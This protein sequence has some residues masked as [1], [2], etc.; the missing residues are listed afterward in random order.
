M[1]T[2]RPRQHVKPNIEIYDEELEIE[3]SDVEE[4]HYSM[5]DDVDLDQPVE[6]E[7]EEEIEEDDNYSESSE[8]SDGVVDGL[9]QEDMDKFQ[10]TFTGIKE[11]YRLINRIGEGNYILKKHDIPVVLQNYRDVF[12]GLQGRRS[13]V[14]RV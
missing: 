6:E 9:V 14:P 5:A 1:A 10:E 13:Q 8:E 2:V 7:E 11:R 3:E 4:M 12:H